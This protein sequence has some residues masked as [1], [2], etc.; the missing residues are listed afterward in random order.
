MCERTTR[1]QAAPLGVTNRCDSF[2][3]QL[4]FRLAAC[5]SSSLFL[6]LVCRLI[7]TAFMF[8]IFYFASPIFADLMATLSTTR[9]D[10]MNDEI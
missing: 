3:T 4:P 10:K 9:N 5:Q 2:V 8:F 7:K 1:S 6:I